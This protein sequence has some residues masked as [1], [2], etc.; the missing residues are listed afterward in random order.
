MVLIVRLVYLRFHA[1]AVIQVGGCTVLTFL[2]SSGG[3]TSIPKSHRFWYVTR[4]K[5]PARAPAPAWYQAWLKTLA[6]K[7]KHTK[8]SRDKRNEDRERK[9]STRQLERRRIM[10]GA[11][12]DREVSEKVALGR[13]DILNIDRGDV[14]VGQGGR[15]LH[16]RLFRV[17]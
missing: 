10:S 16:P 13:S 8:P 11:F 6:E 14:L 3:W 5:P 12:H 17:M 7:N 1:H 15:Y 4:T 2:R 9:L